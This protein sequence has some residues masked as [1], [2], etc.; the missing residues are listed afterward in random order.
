MMA[1]PAPTPASS[2]SSPATS[3][4]PKSADTAENEP[5]AAITFWP[6]ALTRT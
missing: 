4:P 2:S 1:A 5:A 6:I 3:G